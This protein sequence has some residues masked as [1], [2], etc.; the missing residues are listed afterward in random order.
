[1]YEYS[2]TE[3]QQ[4]VMYVRGYPLYAAHL[5]VAAFVVSMLATTLL[6]AANVAFIWDWLPFTSAG[7]L[8]GQAWRVLTYG[9]LN[10]PSL[11][12]LIDTISSPVSSMRILFREQH[13]HLRQ[14]VRH[15]PIDEAK[16]TIMQAITPV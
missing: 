9:F 4:P 7:V 10:P 12:F 6:M 3:E 11:G 13:E 15:L 5:L 14:S 16:S 1:M 2:P 8:R